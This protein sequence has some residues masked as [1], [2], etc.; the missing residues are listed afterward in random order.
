MDLDWVRDRCLRLPHV[1]EDVKWETN[2]AFCVGGKMF[3]VAGLEPDEI[4]LAFK[5][6]QDDYAELLER[7]GCRPAPYLARAQWIALENEH[8]LSRKEL[9]TLLEKAYAIVRS[10][11]P[12]KTRQAL[13]AD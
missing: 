13:E 4:W 11:L 10:K 6:S 9:G 2:L 1:A 8:S 7:P 3:A 12:K 5:C